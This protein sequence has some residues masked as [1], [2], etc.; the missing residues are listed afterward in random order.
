MI[1]HRNKAVFLF[2]ILLLVAAGAPMQV[3][4]SIP[5]RAQLQKQVILWNSIYSME[6]E[7]TLSIMT[8]PSSTEAQ[9]E[10]G[11][12]KKAIL[13][14]VWPLLKACGNLVAIEKVPSHKDTQAILDLLNKLV[15]IGG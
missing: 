9:K 8:S 10:M 12:K 15:A 4:N 1:Q 5:T 3:G 11:R 6:Y 13:V 7:D 14:Q 2:V